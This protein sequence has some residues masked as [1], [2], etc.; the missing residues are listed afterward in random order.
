M[1][2]EQMKV[3][4]SESLLRNL[5]ILV[6]TYSITVEEIKF[7][8][9]VMDDSVFPYLKARY[10]LTVEN[11]VNKALQSVIEEIDNSEILANDYFFSSDIHF[12]YRESGR[13]DD[14]IMRLINEV[15]TK[16]D[17]KVS[18]NETSDLTLFKDF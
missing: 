7:I 9:K 17:M 14:L 1:N 11:D 18:V 16:I 12:E 10:P 5:S 3:F 15:L 6:D 8:D 13:Y 4:A 2:Y